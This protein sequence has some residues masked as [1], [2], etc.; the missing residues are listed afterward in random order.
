MQDR[1]TRLLAVRSMKHEPRKR[2]MPP[3]HS[4]PDAAVARAEATELISAVAARLG[5]RRYD[6][7]IAP[8]E[9]RMGAVGSRQ[10]RTAKDLLNDAVLDE[11]LPDDLVTFVD[12]DYY[13]EEEDF[14]KFAGHDMA[15][16]G[17]QP[18]GLA[19]V[20]SDS[21]WAFEDGKTVVET[22]N[23]GAAYRHQVWDWGKDFYVFEARGSVY[24]YDPVVFT[25]RPNRVV[26]VLLL[27]RTLSWGT[28]ARWLMP[29]LVEHKL[30]RMAVEQQ[31]EYLVGVF[32][33]AD[34]RIVSVRPRGTAHQASIDVPVACFKALEIAAK[35]PNTDRKLTSHDLIPAAVERIMRTFKLQEW[36]KDRPESAYILSDYFT[37]SY[38]PFQLVNYQC[39]GQLAFEDGKPT[40][41]LA[42][43]PLVGAGCGPTSSENNEAQAVKAR[44]EE[45]RNDKAFSRELAGYGQEFARLLVV[46]PGLGVPLDMHELRD[47]QSRPV[48]VAR[49]VAEEQFLPNRGGL[50][51][52]SFQKRESYAKPGDP[53]L[54]NQVPTDHT[55]RLG[56]YSLAIKEL[57]KKGRNARWYMPGKTPLEIAECLQGLQ[58]NV[59]EQLAG[60]DYSRMDG[61]TSN[62]Y[63][64]HVLLPVYLRYFHRS[65]HAEIRELLSKEQEASTR[66]QKFGIRAGLT[67]ANISGSG[68][69]TD[70]NTLD[71]AFNEYVAR[72]R[73]G[74]S[75]EM[76][77]RRLGCYFGDD[78]AVDP[79]VFEDVK[80]VA[81]ETGMSLTREPVPE[82][83]GPGYVVFLSRVYPDIRATLASHPCTIRALRK[84]VTVQANAGERPAIVLARLGLKTAGVLI[85]DPN[86][87]V[88]SDWAKALVRV[89]GLRDVKLSKEAWAGLIREDRGYEAKRALGAFPGAGPASDLLLSSIGW[90]L[91][92]TVQEVRGLVARINA[93]KTEND[94]LGI[95]VATCGQFA[96]PSDT[97]VPNDG[98]WVPTPAPAI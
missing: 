95:A 80:K 73:L 36:L 65:Y 62:G 61:R 10:M 39:G 42:G 34:Q 11:L 18:T 45:V 93:A 25:I 81:E 68:I 69:T 50:A 5:K 60:C 92:L 41:V 35:I 66:T 44:I 30:A 17:L 9:R 31:G 89:M 52:T 33:R 70:L 51:T 13:L 67:G 19:G 37:R 12:T 53:R 2:K 90:D 83:A 6:T 57:F 32:G 85:S 87:P 3:S 54:V 94:L 63:R 76:A 28:V 23:G 40:T 15:L 56:A 86:V 91:G 7:S 21:V 20:T 8:R 59:G 27:A 47:K 72:R 16:Y 29:D 55:N 43:V 77:F 98:V 48:Q 26:V 24:L 22:V 64:E 78:S 88:L 79:N 84:L 75:P 58:R 71:S 14:A 82:E 97:V 49:R 96:S 38:K 4:H 46:K 74:Q 1:S